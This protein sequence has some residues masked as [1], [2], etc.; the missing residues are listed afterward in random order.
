M[1]G[2]PLHFDL[3]HLA[4]LG[5]QFSKDSCFLAIQFGLE[6]AQAMHGNPYML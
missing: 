5:N 3:E 4:N 6:S 1:R 2:C